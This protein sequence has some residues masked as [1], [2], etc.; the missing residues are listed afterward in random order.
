[1]GTSLGERTPAVTRVPG[2]AWVAWIAVC[3]IWGTTYLGIRVSLETIPPNL[4]SGIR[5]TIA[6]L[7]VAAVLLARGHALPEPRAWPGLALLSVLMIGIG[8]GFVVW[9]EQYV[10]SGLTAVVLATSPFWMVA[11]EAPLRGGE[12][13]TRGNISGLLVGFA[14][15]LLLVWPDL[16]TGGAGAARFGMGLIALQLACVGWALGSAWS[17]RHGTDD[18]VF[19]ATAVQMFLGGGLMLALGTALGEWGALSFSTRTTVALV[20]LTGVGSIGGFVAYIYAL[21][22][23]PVST[24]S[25]YAYIN[26]VIAVILGALVLGEPFGVRIVLASALVLAGLAMVRVSSARRERADALCPAGPAG[27]TPATRDGAGVRTSAAPAR[28]R[29]SDY[30]SSAEQSHEE[31]H[32]GDD[33]QHPDEVPE[34][35]ATHHSKQPQHDQNDRNRLKHRSAP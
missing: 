5:W 14:G 17:K 25:L 28:L 1:M 22:H 12:R 4:M 2:T 16:Q 18:N 35:V 15:I 27:P 29:A 6:G 9:A 19:G 8:N 11:V 7:L 3:V 20:Y 10:P 24:V 13:L 32:H 34:R 30:P 26:P 31:Q 21:R 23:L 33:Q